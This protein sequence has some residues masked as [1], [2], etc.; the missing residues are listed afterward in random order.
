VFHGF[1]GDR[2]AWAGFDF[3]DAEWQA[4]PSAP[5]PINPAGATKNGV[6]VDGAI[7]DDIRRCGCPVSSP[8]PQENYQW[9]GMQG[10]ATQATLL[11]AAGYSDIWERSDAAIYRATRFLYEQA[12]FPADNDDTFVPFLLD[13]GL[14]TEF[15]AGVAARSGKS[16]GYTDYTHPTGSTAVPLVEYANATNLTSLVNAADYSNDLD[17]PVLRLYR[18]YFNRE[19]DLDG[20]KY[21]LT[22]RRNGYG[23]LQIAGF[24]ADGQEFANNYT[25]INDTEYLRRIYYNMLDRAAD[26]AGHNYWLDLL[27][28]TNDHGLNPNLHQLNRSE[29]V[30]SVTGGQEF[31]NTYPY[32]NTE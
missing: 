22:I 1:L 15:S 14:G 30:F 29:V 9:E 8:A 28:G 11:H 23:L 3:G 18:A 31:V 27:Q 2:S 7:V 12:N 10:I 17:A 13:A 21:W 5:V 19:P 26:Q 20:A 16:I 25:G 32:T 4:N 6:N 24:M